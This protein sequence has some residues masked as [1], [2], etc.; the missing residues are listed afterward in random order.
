MGANQIQRALREA[1]LGIRRQDL[2]ALVRE[3]T[4]AQLVMSDLRRLPREVVIPAERI[5]RAATRIAAPFEFVVRIGRDLET[6]EYRMIT[7]LSDRPRSLAE[8]EAEAEQLI[9]ENLEGYEVERLELSEPTTVR[10]LRSGAAGI[11]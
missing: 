5:P 7:I 2:L 3:A 6:G 9:A 8:V 10:V 4:G 1:G 11:F